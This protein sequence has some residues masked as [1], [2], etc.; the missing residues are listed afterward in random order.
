MNC[1]F[2]LVLAETEVFHPIFFGTEANV[3]WGISGLENRD[4]ANSTLDIDLTAIGAQLYFGPVNNLSC[5]GRTIA[6]C[7]MGCAF[8]LENNFC[9][10]AFQLLTWTASGNDRFAVA[11]IVDIPK[12]LIPETCVLSIRRLGFQSKDLLGLFGVYIDDVLLMQQTAPAD[13][14]S[15][16]QV[17]FKQSI[18]ALQEMADVFDTKTANTILFSVQLSEAFSFDGCLKDHAWYSP[19]GSSATFEIGLGTQQFQ[20]DIVPFHAILPNRASLRASG[21]TF[22]D[23]DLINNVHTCIAV[24]ASEFILADCCQ[25]TGSCPDLLLYSHLE[26]GF[27]IEAFVR[28]NQVT[29]IKPDFRSTNLEQEQTLLRFIS[30]SNVPSAT[31]PTAADG[32]VPNHFF[33]SMRA[34]DQL[35]IVSSE[36]ITIDTSAPVFTSTNLE[37]ESA[38]LTN[39]LPSCPIQAS[40]LNPAARDNEA[41]LLAIETDFLGSP[42]AVGA[43][44]KA[45]DDQSPIS[46]YYISI[47]SALKFDI[48]RNQEID[49]SEPVVVPT[50]LLQQ[51]ETVCI[52]V[53]AEN[54]AGLMSVSKTSCARVDLSEPNMNNAFLVPLVD[55]RQTA[56]GHRYFVSSSNQIAFSYGGAVD[57]ESSIG[58]YEVAIGTGISGGLQTNLLPKTAFNGAS[59]AS[60]KI[61]ESFTQVQS[62]GQFQEATILP[63]PEGFNFEFEP[64]AKYY[65]SLFVTNRA[66]LMSRLDPVDVLMLPADVDAQVLDAGVQILQLP[67][68]S[69]RASEATSVILSDFSALSFPAGGL[70]VG[71]VSTTALSKTYLSSSIDNTS[72]I[73]YIQDVTRALPTQLARSLRRRDPHLLGFNFFITQI[74]GPVSG[75]ITFDVSAVSAFQ[76]LP[77]NRTIEVV[78]FDTTQDAW[79]LISDSC[80]LSMEKF[81]FCPGSVLSLDMPSVM[82]SVVTLLPV[83]D[84]APML[85]TSLVSGKPNMRMEFQLE[86]VDFEFDTAEFLLLEVRYGSVVDS[87]ADLTLIPTSGI[88]KFFP[89]PYYTGTIHILVKVQQTGSALFSVGTVVVS[90]EKEIMPSMLFYSTNDYTLPYS[91]GLEYVAPKLENTAV[92]LTVLVV[93]FES[94]RSRV[95]CDPSCNNAYP[96]RYNLDLAFQWIKQATCPQN[97]PCNYPWSQLD[98]KFL[99]V[100]VSTYSV[101]LPPQLLT[102]SITA[103]SDRS[104]INEVDRIHFV[105]CTQMEYFVP[106]LISGYFLQSHKY[107]QP[108]DPCPAATGFVLPERISLNSTS[109]KACISGQTFQSN[110]GFDSCQN[111]IFFV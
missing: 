16:N 49:L 67:K 92:E 63:V 10:E 80:N 9:S 66:G 19:L 97:K 72:Y 100:Y 69:R 71:E 50:R 25:L 98:F 77:T 42:R 81:A 2:S 88:C 93:D 43:F 89:R 29:D 73:P 28:E 102:V 32:M 56:S 52:S 108:L 83:I 74:E 34:L 101:F 8:N 64:G 47:G 106:S 103:A 61:T 11:S 59:S 13:M 65:L 3:N 31:K 41:N 99:S 15:V 109:C 12:R 14:I 85:K 46:K 54:A 27:S 39:M 23:L 70:I 30:M 24:C 55:E 86:Y 84:T 78:Y 1:E 110:R 44:A 58:L 35:T 21:P 22:N 82:L 76:N 87:S 51:N 4:T 26:S 90:L 48:V 6:A 7:R 33:V 96:A 105:S 5:T 38:S 45:V 18:V 40:I 20:D 94:T 107:C 57:I 104:R 62:E 95:S 91:S 53:S 36:Q 111:G 17:S 60:V 75:R 79:H 37:C 68:R